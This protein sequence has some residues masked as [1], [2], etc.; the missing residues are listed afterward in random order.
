M[1]VKVWLDDWEFLELEDVISIELEKQVVII[2]T[3]DNEMS[4]LIMVPLDRIV[5]LEEIRLTIEGL[6]KQLEERQEQTGNEDV[7]INSL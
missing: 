5:Y 3:R 1:K 6:R 2:R 4:K 7:K